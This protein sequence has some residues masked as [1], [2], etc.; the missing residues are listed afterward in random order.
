MIS[1]FQDIFD[2]FQ[3]IDDRLEQDVE[4]F[5]I[6]GVVLLYQGLKPATKDIDLVVSS[7]AKFAALEK[8]LLQ[9]DFKGR[10]PTL[11]YWHFTL[12]Q[13]F[14]RG[15]FRIDLFHHQVCG[16]FFL[17]PGMQERA[18]LVKKFPRLSL[19][20]CSNEDIFLFKTMTE[21]E[22]DLEDCLALAK[23]ELKW[24]IILQELQH[25]MNNTGNKVWVTWTGERLDLLQERGLNIPIMPEIDALRYEYYGELEKRM[26]K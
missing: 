5:A 16:E 2:L 24:D 8:A 26:E 15:D 23:R 11:E 25:Q 7:Q 18:Q 10:K 9:S 12:S 6:G 4:I 13:I 22:G 17:S 1:V 14:L 19:F 20:L 3:E 21:R